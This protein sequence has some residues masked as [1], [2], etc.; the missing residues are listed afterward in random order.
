L[1]ARRGDGQALGF[2]TIFWTWS[3]LSAARIA[4][5]NDLY[6]H[7]DARGTGLAEALIGACAEACLERGNVVFLRWQTAKDN[8]RAQA[9]YDRVGATREEWL[10]YSIDLRTS[11]RL[12]RDR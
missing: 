12:P 9:L 7:P 8:G 2:T 4:V 3:T 10:D 1:I 6:V 11:S 5:M